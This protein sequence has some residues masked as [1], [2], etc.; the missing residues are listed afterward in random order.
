MRKI[1]RLDVAAR[2]QRAAGDRRIL[3]CSMR[4]AADDAAVD[5]VVAGGGA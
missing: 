3:T 4:V 5:V 1:E 2:L